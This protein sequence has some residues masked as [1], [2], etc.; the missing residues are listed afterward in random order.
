V[1]VNTMKKKIKKIRTRLLSVLSVDDE[2]D[3]DKEDMTK[4]KIPTLVM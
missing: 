1:Y 2:A 4:R 3:I